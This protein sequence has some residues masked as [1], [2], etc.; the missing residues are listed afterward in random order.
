MGI[1]M[2][3]LLCCEAETN[4]AWYANNY[5]PIKIKEKKTK[6]QTIGQTK[7]WPSG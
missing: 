6:T 5:S 3:D 1:H 7:G 4:T 2:A